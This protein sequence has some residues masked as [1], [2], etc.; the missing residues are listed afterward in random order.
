MS[1]QLEGKLALVTGGSRGIGRAVVESFAAEGAEVA[2]TYRS[3]SDE[4]K[5]IV[6]SI[7]VSG[8]KAHAIKAD[9]ADEKQILSLFNQV[10]ELGQLDILVNNAGVILEKSLVETTAEEFDWLMNINLRGLFLCGREGLRRMAGNGGRVINITSDLSFVG[11]E[12]FSVY[13]ASKGAINALTKSW[14]R[15]FAPNVLVNAIAPGPIDTDMLDLEHMSP[16]WQKKEKEL[17]VLKR[18]GKP[19]EASSVAVFLAGPGGSYI[20]GQ[21]IGPNGGSVMP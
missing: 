4:A 2:F 17:T 7:A 19:Q 20:T 13:C 3:G 18:I 8:G 16:E 6:S 15:E 21:I 1:G 10:D 9:I 12:E 14:A 11:R 5:E